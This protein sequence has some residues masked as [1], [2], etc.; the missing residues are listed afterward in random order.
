MDISAL[1]KFVA[2]AS[3]LKRTSRLGK[4]H[5]IFSTQT[6]MTDG[7]EFDWQ[8]MRKTSYMAARGAKQIFA[9][10]YCKRKMG[11]ILPLTSHLLCEFT[12]NIFAI[13]VALQVQK[14]LVLF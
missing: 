9:A 1:I 11:P 7:N 6:Q 4:T 2:L 8:T 12:C 3:I 14:A 5:S 13:K 10:Q